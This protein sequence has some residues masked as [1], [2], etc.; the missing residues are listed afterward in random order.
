M[1]TEQTNALTTLNANSCTS[2]GAAV[3]LNNNPGHLTGTYSPGCYSSTGAMDI[4]AGTTV[5]LNGAGVYIFRPNGDL[6]TG[7]NS[8]VILAS[9][10]CAT[11]V[12]WTPAGG[13]TLGANAATSPL[14]PT[15][16]GNIFRG[17]AAGLSI[18]LGH[19]AHLTG[20]ALAF[21]STVTTDSNTIDVPTCA[22]FTGGGGGGL[23]PPTVTK[24]FNPAS[25]AVGDV[26]R[27]TIT[28]SNP[29]AAAI[30]LTTA[31]TDTFPT[32]VVIAAVP[33]LTTTCGGAAIAPIGGSTVNLANLSTIPSGSCTIAVNV[34]AT[35]VGAYLNTIP[36]GALQ[37][38]AGINIAATAPLA[39]IP[40]TPTPRPNVC[41]TTAPDLFI[42]KRHTDLFVVGTNATYSIGLFN[43][44]VTSSGA[45][46]VTD[47]LPAG[48]TFVSATGASW[49]CAAAGQ[50]VTCTTTASL[51]GSITLTVTPSAS[52]V[53]SVTNAAVVAG[54]GDCD[55]TNNAT[56]DVTLVALA[57]PTFPE[58]AFLMLSVLLAAVGVVAL[59]RR[60]AG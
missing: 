5:T 57:V 41:A 14:V 43:N 12:F 10:A 34:T 38:N 47:T 6:T 19:F 20:R 4:V 45:I 55:V 7:A 36:A 44:G 17:T 49:T 9:G 48:L 46:T 15:F 50:V 11:D 58:W 54:G 52:A 33:N 39:V 13:T 35:A 18:T 1:G 40:P 42:V 53:P 59:R 28:L 32:G 3:A 51:P 31:F 60:A 37:T 8:R 30:A 16:V 21:G 27:L 26:S 29:N 56:S 24:V 23:V 22:A 25:I 2:L